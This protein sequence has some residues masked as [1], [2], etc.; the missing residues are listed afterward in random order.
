[1][2]A[3][4]VRMDALADVAE[5]DDEL[6][7]HACAGGAKRAHAVEADGALPAAATT[8]CSSACAGQVGDGVEPG[9]QAA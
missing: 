2:A 1:M 3:M 6:G 7:G 8:S 9:G 4:P 5:A